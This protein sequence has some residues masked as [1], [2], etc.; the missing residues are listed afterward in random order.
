L[1]HLAARHY[2]WAVI[3]RCASRA[4][5]QDLDDAFFGHSKHFLQLTYLRRVALIGV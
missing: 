3:Y 4:D 2:W 5:I 1:R